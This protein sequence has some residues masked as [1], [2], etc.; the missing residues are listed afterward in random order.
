MQFQYT[1]PAVRLPPLP[2]LEFMSLWE[3]YGRCQ[4]LVPEFSTLRQTMLSTQTL[5]ISAETFVGQ[6]VRRDMASWLSRANCGK[7]RGEQETWH[8][9]HVDMFSICSDVRF[10]VG[11]LTYPHAIT[12][13]TT[14]FDRPRPML[15]S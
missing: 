7:F 13:S 15:L 6:W 11:H 9:Y 14:P 2:L 1:T 4:G 12:E 10:L 8:S 3:S 5:H